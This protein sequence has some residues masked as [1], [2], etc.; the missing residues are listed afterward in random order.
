VIR[1]RRRGFFAILLRG[2][3]RGQIRSD[4][5]LV[6]VVDALYGA[7]H[8]RL[9]VTRQPID[10]R[11]ASAL[12]QFVEQ[13]LATPPTADL[14]RPARSEPEIGSHLLPHGDELPGETFTPTSSQV[15]GG[16]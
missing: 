10:E 1:S 7:L 11:F 14:T 6:S 3:Q 13:G 9:L 4:V 5:D 15:A 16:A 12:K 8:H 2:Q